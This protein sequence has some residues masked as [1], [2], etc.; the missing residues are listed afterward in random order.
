MIYILA[1]NTTLWTQYIPKDHFTTK[2]NSKC[3]NVLFFPNTNNVLGADTHSGRKTQYSSPLKGFIVI[4]IW[5]FSQCNNSHLLLVLWSW[6]NG[7]R[8]TFLQQAFKTKGHLHIHYYHYQIVANDKYICCTALINPRPGNE[9]II[10]VSLWHVLFPCKLF[11]AM[12]FPIQFSH[13][14]C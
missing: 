2:W 10:V 13:Y 8:Q 5:S 3:E 7:K 12:A 1:V 4:F 11:I 9:N 14:F 6:V